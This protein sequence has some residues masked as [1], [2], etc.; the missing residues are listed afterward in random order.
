MDAENY[1]RDKRVETV[2][3]EH[4]VHVTRAVGVAAEMLQEFANRSIVRNWIWHWQDCLEP[5][6]ARVITSQDGSTIRP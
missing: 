5:E 1:P 4:E 2:F 3:L 6:S